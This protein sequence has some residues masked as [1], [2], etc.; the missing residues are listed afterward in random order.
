M[1]CCPDTGC[2]ITVFAEQVLNGLGISYGPP[3]RR[4]QIDAATSD[5]IRIVG[6][7]W[8]TITT[9]QGCENSAQIFVLV[10]DNIGDAML[11]AWHNLVEVGVIRPDFPAA[12]PVPDNVRAEFA[13]CWQVRT[14][15]ERT[16]DTIVEEFQ[17]VL[18]EDLK[19]TPMEGPPMKIEIRPDA[20]PRQTKVA[21]QTPLKFQKEAA[22]TIQKLIDRDIIEKV[23][24]GDTAEW[25]S[26]GFF[27]PKSDNVRVRLVTDYTYLNKW[28]ARPIHPFPS[29]QDIVQSIPATARVFAKFDAVNG[30]FQLALDPGSRKY[31]TFLLPSGHY[32]YKRAPMGLKPSSDDWCNRSDGV[33]EGLDW[34]RKIVDDILVWAASWEELWPRIRVILSRCRE[35]NITISLKKMEVGES[36]PFAGFVFSG[37]GIYP[38]PARTEAIREFPKPKNITEL[39]G[40]LGLAQQLGYFVPDLA[41][42]TVDMKALLKKDVAYQWLE[43]QER[44]FQETK[45]ALT[46]ELVVKPFDP[47]LHTILLTDASKLHGLG[48]ALMQ[49]EKEGH[50]LIQCGS[51]STTPTQQR[52]SVSEIECLAIVWAIKKCQYY[53]R[54]LDTF[55]VITD[56]KPLVGI[57]KQDIEEVASERCQRLREKVTQFSFEVS[58]LEGKSHMI[59]DALSRSPVWVS[60]KDGLENLVQ[61]EETGICRRLTVDPALEVITEAVKGDDEYKELVTLVGKAVPADEVKSKTK[62]GHLARRVVKE[63]HALST[64]NLNGVDI[65]L[66]DAKRM[67]L[68]SRARARVLELLHASH[69]GIEKTK[70]TARGMYYWPGMNDDIEHLVTS[71]KTCRTLQPSQRGM[72]ALEIDK[73][74]APGTHYGID[75]FNINTQD[76][77]TMV[78][79]YSGYPFAR[80]LTKTD[81][82]TV[83]AFVEDVCLEVGWPIVIRSDNGPQFRGPFTAR[84]TEQN[85]IHETS[86]PYNPASNG[87]AESS[88]KSV[89]RLIKTCI[90]D[91]KNDF[92][93]RLLEFRNVR[94]ADGFSPAHRF[95]NRAQRTSLPMLPEQLKPISSEEMDRAA[96][97]RFDALQRTLDAKDTKARGLHELE[98]G[99]RVL[100]QDPHNG[101]WRD[102]ATVIAVRDSGRSYDIE[103]E[104]GKVTA[105]NRQFLK[106]EGKVAP[107]AADEAPDAETTSNDSPRRS[108][109][110]EAKAKA[111]WAGPRPAPSVTRTRRSTGTRWSR[112]SAGPDSSTSTWTISTP[113]ISSSSSSPSWPC[114]SSTSSGRRGEDGDGGTG[115]GGAGAAREARTGS[116]RSHHYGVGGGRTR[117]RP[118][119]WTTATPRVWRR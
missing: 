51:C 111:R 31:T 68:P 119:P 64:A 24:P 96:E 82:G 53:L 35:L 18:G 7:A 20:V 49:P 33:I 62:E 95:F 44:S 81:T 78:D 70:V 113:G 77:V 21:R 5:P 39:R 41:H 2:T 47:S 6:N 55:S 116:S 90:E 73:D 42:L 57:F 17:D 86:S 8:L 87:L 92:K 93:A 37:E 100:V 45:E 54:G 11:V 28:V 43:P 60:E 76:W 108:A 74:I 66:K 99:Q 71:C 88:V 19:E 48:F 10:A 16:L 75:L 22:L 112:T 101:E 89:K 25:C 56:H 72:E 98:V 65:V 103:L 12:H 63:W 36:I 83:W 59:A 102:S 27:V 110:L 104:N 32:R 105:R 97:S 9:R 14:T 79:R 52:Y 15:T 115:D 26:P 4:I 30:Y 58:W 61:E 107:S 50:R 46:S 85:I 40:F 91:K 118:S 23:P 29:A 1:D 80:R 106:P 109:R 94:R 84:C 117:S 69:A 13:K 34:C 114:S 67:V 38:D 3:T